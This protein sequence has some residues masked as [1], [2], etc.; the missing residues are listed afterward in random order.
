MP[1]HFGVAV[2][3]DKTYEILTLIEQAE[4]W[5]CPTFYTS[6]NAASCGPFSIKSATSRERYFIA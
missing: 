2:R 6:G 1:H 3:G 4:Q 5:V